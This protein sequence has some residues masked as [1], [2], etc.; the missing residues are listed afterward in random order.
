MDKV[1]IVDESDL[2]IISFLSPI[3]RN[4]DVKKK[5]INT[6]MVKIIK[7]FLFVLFL[8]FIINSI[9]KKSPKIGD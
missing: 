3:K 9:I 2:S 1:D 7:N 5:V 6:M 4:I 8:I